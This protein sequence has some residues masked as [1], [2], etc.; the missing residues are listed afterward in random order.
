[1]CE[2]ALLGV[3]KL[4]LVARSDVNIGHVEHGYDGQGLT[5]AVE[6]LAGSQD[7]LGVERVEG[8]IGH[9]LAQFCEV[10]FVV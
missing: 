9:V 1:V 10:T 8:V 5:D 6:L 4:L 3:S 7:D 2:L